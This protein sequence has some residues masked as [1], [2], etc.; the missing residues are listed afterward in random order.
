ML[1]EGSSG[2]LADSLEAVIKSYKAAN[3]ATKAQE[4]ATL[5]D[6]YND[7]YKNSSDSDERFAATAKLT[8]VGLVT[9]G[10]IKGYNHLTRPKNGLA[11]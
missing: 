8:A 7:D 6:A 11:K 3:D 10:L 5:G 4:L 1:I 9:Y 2:F